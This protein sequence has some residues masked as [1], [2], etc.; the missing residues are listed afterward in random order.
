M[1]KQLAAV[2]TVSF[3]VSPGQQGWLFWSM[4]Q[5]QV[6]LPQSITGRRTKVHS[7]N[8]IDPPKPVLLFRYRSNRLDNIPS[9]V[10]IVPVSPHDCISRYSSRVSCPS[11]EGIVPIRRGLWAT[12][13]P[14]RIVMLPKMDGIELVRSLSDNWR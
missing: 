9:S 6:M 3:V 1:R 14:P 7:W 11:S 10:G 5:L 12:Y 4:Q 13:R 2:L 8:G